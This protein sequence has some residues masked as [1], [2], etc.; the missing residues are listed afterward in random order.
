MKKIGIFF[1]CVLVSI[2]TCSYCTSSSF[3]YS[4]N[5]KASSYNLKYKRLKISD[6]NN[7][8]Y[9]FDSVQGFK[10]DSTNYYFS[11][12][13]PRNDKWQVGD[14]DDSYNINFGDGYKSCRVLNKTNDFT[15][16]PT[17]SEEITFNIECPVPKNGESSQIGILYSIDGRYNKSS[18]S[19]S[20]YEYIES[21]FHNFMTY[22][23]YINNVNRTY[24]IRN[25]ELYIHKEHRGAAPTYVYNII[26]DWLNGE[27]SSG[28]DIT[29]DN[30]NTYLYNKLNPND[31]FYISNYI[32]SIKNNT[33]GITITEQEDSNGFYKLSLDKDY[34][35][36]YV[37]THVNI[38]PTETSPKKFYFYGRYLNI[39]NDAN[40]LFEDYLK[41]Y[42]F[43]SDSDK[44]KEE[45]RAVTNFINSLSGKSIIDLVK[46]NEV[47][48]LVLNENELTVSNSFTL[49][50]Y[51]EY[52]L[53][54]FT[55][56]S[57]YRLRISQ[58][59]G[60]PISSLGET[61]HFSDDSVD[62]V[63]DVTNKS[64]REN[65][66]YINNNN[67]ND[68]FKVLRTYP[69]N[70]NNTSSVDIYRI[71]KGKTV[72]FDYTGLVS[73]TDYSKMLEFLK[74][75]SQYMYEYNSNDIAYK[76]SNNKWNIIT[77]ADLI[78]VGE[79]KV[80]DTNIGKVTISKTDGKILLTIEFT[81]DNID[82]TID[83]ASIDNNEEMLAMNE[84]PLMMEKSIE[85]EVVDEPHE[86]FDTEDV[87]KDE[88]IEKVEDDCLDHYVS[89]TIDKIDEDN[90]TD[91]NI[92][93]DSNTNTN[94][95]DNDKLTDNNT[96]N[97]IVGDSD[98]S[99]DMAVTEPQKIEIVVEDTKEIDYDSPL[100]DDTLS[101]ESD[102]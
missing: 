89:E 50:D 78:P 47:D 65:Y 43:S 97:I 60:I 45:M 20:D 81:T 27:Y 24:F 66:Y 33:K 91:N 21:R 99:I 57:G 82:V 61:P 77:A 36:G 7:I 100:V 42:K 87:D 90:I 98:N 4:E 83:T 39:A 51:T 62:K 12:A 79:S 88:T 71:K 37:R 23:D 16:E 2:Y 46:N 40:K 30:I 59:T 53:D 56:L 15:S 74:D 22:E 48:G 85:T 101:N 94:D 41:E 10:S 8:K 95:N 34:F 25:H 9:S 72:E 68:L 31:S 49:L 55:T 102:L 13:F 26:L 6:G 64:I 67:D 80:F 70:D 84:E 3:Y 5:N 86:V 35:Q 32:D 38:L 44:D 28:A 92:N 52:E 96:D 63:Y 11:I 14:Q 1:T 19:E 29:S 17:G 93:T 75:L 18:T 73:D 69:L 76:D 54:S 58:K